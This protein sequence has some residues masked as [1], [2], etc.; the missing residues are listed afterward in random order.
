MPAQTIL[1]LSALATV[2][3]FTFCFIADLTTTL[4]QAWKA[5]SSAP[6]PQTEPIPEVEPAPKPPVYASLN[7]VQ[8]QEE[9][10]ITEET[11]ILELAKA[12]LP[13]LQPIIITLAQTP[14][15]EQLEEWLAVAPSPVSKFTT[16]RPDYTKLTV[17][18]LRQEAKIRNLKNASGKTKKDLIAALLAA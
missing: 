1:T 13:K 12:R 16:P 2:T 6:T 10:E 4:L 18:Q 15:A 14:E 11:D 17:K 3:V 5:A 9:Q 8:S 7:W